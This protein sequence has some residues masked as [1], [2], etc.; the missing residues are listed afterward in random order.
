MSFQFI[1]LSVGITW[2]FNQCLKMLISGRPKIFFEHGGMPSSHTAFASALAT[3]VGYV[4]G[5]TSPMFLITLG[6]VILILHSASKRHKPQEIG[7]GVLVGIL[8]VT[9]FRLLL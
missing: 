6:L 4:E 7:V 9:L 5:W 8:G 1:I 2:L 3:A